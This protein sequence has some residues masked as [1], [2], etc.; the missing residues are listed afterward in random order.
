M[1]LGATVPSPPQS[2]LRW[3]GLVASLGGEA[4]IQSFT[5]T[6][7]DPGTPQDR[8][9]AGVN[10]EPNTCTE[11]DVDPLTVCSTGAV[12]FNRDDCPDDVE[13]TPLVYYEAAKRSTF[14]EVSTP[15]DI[16]RQRLIN[17]T[18]H[19]LE[20]EFWL[21]EGAQAASYA[22]N[23]YLVDANLDQVAGGA[24]V[25]LTYGFAAAV[26][27]GGV[28]ADGQRLMHHMSSFIAVLLYSAGVIRREAGLLLDLA[29]NIIVAGTG[30]PLNIDGSA[31]DEVPTT[32]WMITTLV[33]Q[34]RLGNVQ[35]LDTYSQ[36]NN[37]RIGIAYRAGAVTMDT[38][39]QIGV[40][41]DLCNICCA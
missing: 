6:A 2:A 5:T 8:W 36:T 21:G 28:A 39:V 26:R 16:A 19:K 9:E 14:T 31:D 11:D 41:L 7:V 37:E 40:N 38:C 17:T 3:P 35:E 4:A 34:V 24:A 29:D 12:Q 10:F 1:P 33:P 32:G 15:L 23:Q 13:M 18:S 25:P 22:G 20:R 27:A 30:Y